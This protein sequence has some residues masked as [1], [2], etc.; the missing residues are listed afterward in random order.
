MSTETQT[1]LQESVQDSGV[2][3]FRRYKFMTN[4]LVRAQDKE[5]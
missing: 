2:M 1:D 5:T 4:I 3:N